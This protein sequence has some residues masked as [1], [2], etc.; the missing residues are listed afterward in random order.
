MDRLAKQEENDMLIV[1]SFSPLFSTVSPLS[2]HQAKMITRPPFLRTFSTYVPLALNRPSLD[3]GRGD[4]SFKLIF[5]EMTFANLFLASPLRS[6]VSLRLTWER[7]LS[8]ARPG[9][10][11]Q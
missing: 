11:A 6:V 7:I 3:G 8:W 10:T 1:C 2:S 9:L 4:L 5:N